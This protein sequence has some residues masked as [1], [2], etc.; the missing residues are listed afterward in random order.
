MGRSPELAGAD[1]S[2]GRAMNKAEVAVIVLGLTLIGATIWIPSLSDR[3]RGA[4]TADGHSRRH[5][6]HAA[7]TDGVMTEADPDPIGPD[8]RVR[9]R[10]L[11]ADGEFAVVLCR[12]PG[13]AGL[14]PFRADLHPRGAC[15]TAG[16]AAG[17]CLRAPARHTL[18]LDPEVRAGPR[19][20]GGR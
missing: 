19:L 7:P 15:G 2:T 12:L 4:A 11:F 9:L 6:A 5:P 3:T 8:G 17:G 10:G 14:R 18:D 13:P 1:L 16:A 20:K